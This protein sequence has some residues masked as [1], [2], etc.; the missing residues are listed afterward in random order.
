M[1]CQKEFQK[2]VIMQERQVVLLSVSK[3]HFMYNIVL[4]PART[5]FIL[6]VAGRV[7]GQRLINTTLT[8]PGSFQVGT[9]WQREQLGSL[10]SGDSVF[11]FPVLSAIGI[12]T[13]FLSHCCFQ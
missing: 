8:P 2:A 13:V 3:W 11:T 10:A 7:H 12:V 1:F 6:A 5:G 9:A 4:V